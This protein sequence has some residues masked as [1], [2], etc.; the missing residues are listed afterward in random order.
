M[1]LINSA[2]QIRRVRSG[3]NHTSPVADRGNVRP[4][5]PVARQTLHRAP[6]KASPRSKLSRG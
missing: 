5:R 4:N 6:V 1:A 2:E 3:V